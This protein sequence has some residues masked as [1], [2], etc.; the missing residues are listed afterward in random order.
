MLVPLKID[1]KTSL[2]REKKNQD[3]EFNILDVSQGVDYR[4]AEE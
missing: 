2:L 3:V 1:E 4:Y